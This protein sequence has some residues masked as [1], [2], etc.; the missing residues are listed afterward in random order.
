MG[1][2]TCEDFSQPWCLTMA[3]DPGWKLVTTFSLTPGPASTQNSLVAETLST[4]RGIRA[5]QT[6]LLQSPDNSAAPPDTAQVRMMFSL[7]DGVNGIAGTCHGG[8]IGLMLDEV[9]G[10]LASE[11]FGRHNIIKAGLEV[12]YKRKISTPAVVLCTARLGEVKGRKARVEGT[13][14][15]GTGGVYAT[16]QTVFVKLDRKL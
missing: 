7:G 5:V 6:Y 8:L 12:A 15:D 4:A 2:E 3:K 16:G 11:V 14:E 1:Q 13:I 9:T 10:Q